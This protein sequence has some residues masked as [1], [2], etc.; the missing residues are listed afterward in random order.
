MPDLRADAT[1]DWLNE[2]RPARFAEAWPLP[3]RAIETS[4]QATALLVEFGQLLDELAVRSPHALMTLLADTDDLQVILAQVGA[5][6][7]LACFHWLR[8]V[9]LPGHLALE[10]SLL[11][12]TTPS[13]RA[14]FATITT[15][16]RQATLRRLVSMQRMDELLSATDSANKETPIV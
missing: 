6:R 9:G 15:V 2:L 16:A 5:A 12:G 13:G 11:E 14:L 10:K 8:Q 7:S 4:T 3:L 1:T